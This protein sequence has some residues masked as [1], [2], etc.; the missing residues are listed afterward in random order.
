MRSAGDR[1]WVGIKGPTI[2]AEEW[3][4]LEAISPGGI[5]LFRRNIEN[6]SRAKN[7]HPLG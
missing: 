2:F 6:T 1:L 3:D 7:P 4:H 5:I